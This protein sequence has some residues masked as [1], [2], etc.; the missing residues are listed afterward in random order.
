MKLLALVV[1]IIG[2]SF[3]SCSRTPYCISEKDKDVKIRWGEVFIS[4]KVFDGYQ[5]DTKAMLYRNSGYTNS[6]TDDLI[7]LGEVDPELYCT[8]LLRIRDE[9]LKVQALNAPGDTSRYVEYVDPAN[10]IS[11]R[12]LWNPKFKTYLSEGF[13]GIYDSLQIFTNINNP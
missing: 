6:K 5:L 1:F 11:V 8:L 2:L 7:L 4:Q 10:N 3:I 12:A 9:F 13:R